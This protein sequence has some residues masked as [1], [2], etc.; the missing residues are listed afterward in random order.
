[1]A[2]QCRRHRGRPFPG[3]VQQPKSSP[4]WAVPLGQSQLRSPACAVPVAQSRLRSP[5]CADPLAQSRLRSPTCTVPLAQSRLHSPAWAVPVAQSQLRSPSCAVPVAQSRLRST[6]CL[7]TRCGRMVLEDRC[8][9]LLIA[10]EARGACACTA[11]RLHP[12][13]AAAPLRPGPFAQSHLRSP[14][15]AVPLA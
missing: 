13:T 11:R 4:A 8:P 15:C 14:T 6:A 1:M 5:A 12:C 10:R 2:A 7:I 9:V 3:C